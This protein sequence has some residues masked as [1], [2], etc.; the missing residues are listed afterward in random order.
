MTG[1]GSA[2]TGRTAAGLGSESMARSLREET[3]DHVGL[4]HFA[5]LIEVVVDH[6][7]RVEADAVVNRRYELDGMHGAFDRSRG[8]FVGLPEHDAASGPSAGDDSGIAI[9]PVVPAV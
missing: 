4:H 5:R 6:R 8:R 9:G 2:R 3:V 7:A 1:N